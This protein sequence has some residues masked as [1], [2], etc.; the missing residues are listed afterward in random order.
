[1]DMREIPN[2]LFAT[3]RTYNNS[4]ERTRGLV[5]ARTFSIREY[6]NKKGFND[7]ALL[8]EIIICEASKDAPIIVSGR[9]IIAKG[10]ALIYALQFNPI[11]NEGRGKDEKRVHIFGKAFIPQ[12]KDEIESIAVIKNNLTGSYDDKNIAGKISCSGIEN[13]DITLHGHANELEMM[14]SAAVDSF[15]QKRY[16]LKTDIRYANGLK[17]EYKISISNDD[18][19]KFV[20]SISLNI[21]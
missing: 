8:P 20:K 9:G 3:E 16:D 14:L 18:M 13:R 5:V 21:F 19:A 12:E 1:M 7:H 6:I 4:I 15:P 10:P 2:E 11:H 17:K